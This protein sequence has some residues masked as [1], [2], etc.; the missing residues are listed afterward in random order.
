[1]I[2]GDLISNLLLFVFIPLPSAAMFG[3]SIAK[4]NANANIYKI[5]SA[6]FAVVTGTGSGDRRCVSHVKI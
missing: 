4:R 3:H 6:V 1:M 2:R 5:S